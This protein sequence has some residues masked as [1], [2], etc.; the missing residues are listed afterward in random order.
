MTI[1]IASPTTT[2]TIT[3]N[4]ASHAFQDHRVRHAPA[5]AHGLQ[6][7]AAT[8]ALQLVDERGR[9]TRP[10]T[11][12]RVTQRDRAAVHVDLAHVGVQV[13]LPREHDRRECFVDLYEIHV[14]ERE[15]T[16]R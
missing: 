10:G 4:I 12:Q 6:A 3:S 15:P 16:A 5:L 2:R 7:V 11:T 1:P 9:E 13:V 14:V 8:R